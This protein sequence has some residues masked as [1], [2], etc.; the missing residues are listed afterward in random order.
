[1]ISRKRILSNS[2]RSIS[3]CLANDPFDDDVWFDL[4]SLLRVSIYFISFLQIPH[5]KKNNVEKSMFHVDQDFCFTTIETYLQ[6][7]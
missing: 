1:M 3:Q 5:V 4:N 6:T 2:C 7:I